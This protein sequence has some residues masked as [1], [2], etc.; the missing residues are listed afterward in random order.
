MRASLLLLSVATVLSACAVGPNYHTPDIAT[1]ASY[2]GTQLLP[3]S[4]TASTAELGAWWTQFDDAELN[5][6]IER[7]MQGNLDLKSAASRIREAREQLIIAGADRLPRI[8]ADADVST[9]HLSQNSGLSEFTSLF[10][11]APG[12]GKQGASNG[13]TLPGNNITTY[14]LGFDASWEIDLFG[15]TRRAIEAARANAEEAVWKER[16]SEVSVAAEVASDY[17]LLRSLQRQITVVAEEVKRQEQ[18]LSLV[19]A[20]HQFGFVTEED[21]RAQGAQLASVKSTLPD[22]DAEQ[23][24]EIHA[25]GVLVGTSP[26]ALQDELAAPKSLSSPPTTI[27]V[28]LPSELLR[29]RPDVRAAERALAAASARIGIAVADLYPKIHLTGALD[30][31]S[32]DLRHLLEAS[33]RQSN[34][35]GALSWPIFSAGRGHANIHVA[36]EKDRQALYAYQKALLDALKDVE[37]ALTRYGDELQKNRALRDE[38]SEAQRAADIAQAQYGAGT[39]NI[40]PVLSAQAGVLQAR[41]QLAQSDGALDRDLASLYKALGG[42]WHDPSSP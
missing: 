36:Q 10:S 21:V 34:A 35:A 27:P 37:D 29:R 1:P 31:V 9:A 26:E 5:S 2:S 16:D 32:L 39:I 12:N 22:L 6:L 24:G 41:T 8:N 25:L 3:S 33:S 11:S 15:G 23:A 28:G 20:R 40:T 38:L 17:W 18:I 14:T 19:Q 30:L 42:G 4:A 7:A 13:F